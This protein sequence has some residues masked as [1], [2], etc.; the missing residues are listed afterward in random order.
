MQCVWS[1]VKW[2]AVKWGLHVAEWGLMAGPARLWMFPVPVIPPA[3]FCR[4]QT[5]PSAVA[6]LSRSFWLLTTVQV[7]RV[8]PVKECRQPRQN[9]RPPGTGIPPASPGGCALAGS[10][11][12]MPQQICKAHQPA[13]SSYSVCGLPS[14]FKTKVMQPLNSG[15]P[16]SIEDCASERAPQ[17]KQAGW[18]ASLFQLALT[19]PYG[20]LL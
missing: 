3:L 20:A 12:L 18:C 19:G 7:L 10:T 16:V 15:P 1:A 9:S 14:W 13:Q 11:G 17:N 2:S 6:F 5:L 8:L 4:A